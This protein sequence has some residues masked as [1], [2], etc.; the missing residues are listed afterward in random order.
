MDVW[1]NLLM[2]TDIEWNVL[3]KY[4]IGYTKD[5][6]W[7]ICT[8]YKNI[9]TLDVFLKNKRGK[10]CLSVFIEGSNISLIHRLKFWNIRKKLGK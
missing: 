5:I 9:E 1:Y 6:I 10:F 2:L 3:Y 4:N 7:D 8:F